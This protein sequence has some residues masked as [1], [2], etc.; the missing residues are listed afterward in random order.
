MLF[1]SFFCRFLCGSY[2]YNGR[3]GIEM[4]NAFFKGKLICNLMIH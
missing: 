1:I 4:E 3:C 2:V